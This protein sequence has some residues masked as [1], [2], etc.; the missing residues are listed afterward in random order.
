VTDPDGRNFSDLKVSIIIPYK[1]E[2]WQHIKASLE[3]ILYYTP[4]RYLAEIMF[5]SDGNGP[6]TL[7]V[8][9]L[10]RMSRLVTIFALPPP[11]VGLIEAK[12]RAVG[13]TSVHST[14]LMFLEPHIRVNRAWLTPLLR[15]IRLNPQLLA[16]P[17]LDPIPADDFNAYFAAT[18]G[19]WRF[20]WN[21]NLVYTA[22][23][24]TLQVGKPTTPWPSPA[25]SGGIFAIRKDW[26]N[27]LSFYDHGMIGWGGDHVE[28]TFKVWLCGGRIEIVPCSRVGHMF[29]EPVS[30]PYDVEVEQV[31]RNYG[32]MAKTWFGEHIQYFYKVKPEAE[33]M[34][35]GNI[36]EQL[37]L[38]DRLQCKD[39]SWYL[40][41]V[42]P[43]LNWEKDHICIPGCEKT[44]S[45]ECCDLPGW[46]G[47]STLDRIMPEAEYD[48]SSRRSEVL[49]PA[50][51]QEL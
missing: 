12:M 27:R 23:S 30:R 4:K 13:A 26:W 35:T 37:E 18:A 39:M 5:V 29:R 33:A 9:E 43:E 6:D 38:K 34:D 3:S 8:A 45:P 51:R 11:G 14:V 49:S 42:D 19:V 16:M 25:T 47:R 32:R 40:E 2:K 24:S 31:I 50:A 22:P 36:T 48:A 20:E 46:P 17:A 41:H 10:Q 28:A 44:V 7:Y 1:K 15:R 21:L